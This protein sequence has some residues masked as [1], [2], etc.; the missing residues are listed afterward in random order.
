M[1]S[2]ARLSHQPPV[3]FRVA[4]LYIGVLYCLLQKKMILLKHHLCVNYVGDDFPVNIGS[5]KCDVILNTLFLC[6]LSLGSFSLST[7]IASRTNACMR[8]WSQFINHEIST[9][10]GIK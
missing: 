3:I 9:V 7:N 5:N 1:C 2:F 6:H 8:Y 10:K 4:W